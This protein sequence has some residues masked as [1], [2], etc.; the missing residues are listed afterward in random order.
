MAG[1]IMS[2]LDHEHGGMRS[3]AS[4]AL[5]LLAAVVIDCLTVSACYL[6]SV[7]LKTLGNPELS[8]ALY[9]TIG[10]AF[11]L[12]LGAYA[13]VGLYDLV[14]VGPAEELRRVVVTT[15]LFFIALA[16]ATFLVRG[17]E[18]YSRQVFLT[19]WMGICIAVPLGR[20][21][22]RRLF[23]RMAWW[24]IPVVVVGAGRTGTLVVA[25]LRRWP[26]LGLRPVALVDDAPVAA[27]QEG[28]PVFTGIDHG[29]ARAAVAGVRHAVLS[30]PGLPSERLGPLLDRLAEEF[31]HV[32]IAP[33]L[34][35]M[36][37]LVA[38]TREFAQVLVLEVQ[39]NLLRPDARFTKRLLDLL[40]VM[41]GLPIAAC[42]T[43]AMAVLIPL[44]SHGPVF[45]GQ[46][47]IGRDGRHFTAWK[48][49]TMVRD[50]DAILA[51]HLLDH[52]ELRAEWERDHKL[53]NDPRVTWTGRFLRKTSL[54]ELPQLWNILVGEMSLV[55][56]RPIVDA[57]VPRYGE[58]FA[59]Y[60]KVRPGLTGLWQVSG[61]ND[62]TYEERVILDTY[63]VRNWSVWLDIHI[64]LRTVRV[65]L[66]GSG[67]Y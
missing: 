9:A 20:A 41:A 66:L 1:A 35:G 11:L 55:G 52:P 5:T 24:G 2:I 38:T 27:Q 62:T 22:S 44:T 10:P 29:A 8:L 30:I 51:R 46:T 53:R 25:T 64:I 45:Y 19:T 7:W 48:F 54:D 50:A 60:R 61:R 65:V 14:G 43:A 15:T 3:S 36:P 17:A 6:F 31:R 4:P 63:Y 47:R 58:K 40:L 23:C 67:A 34:P 26:W 59:L 39:A 21:W 13:A 12:L 57:E 42:F 37:G 49:R 28:L 56:P 33:A 16:G 18:L 32:W